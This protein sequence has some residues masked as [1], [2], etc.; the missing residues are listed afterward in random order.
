MRSE[1]IALLVYGV[2][3]ILTG[4]AFA[5]LGPDTD[6][7]TD[8]ITFGIAGMLWPVVVGVALLAG[9]LCG[10][11]M[12]ARWLMKRGERSVRK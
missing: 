8:Y 4:G 10:P 1:A 3:F 5:V 11:P 2:G 6:E 9:I 12:L 7:G